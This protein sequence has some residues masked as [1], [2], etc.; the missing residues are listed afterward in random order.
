MGTVVVVAGIVGSLY[1]GFGALLYFMQDALLFPAPGG[2]SVAALDEAAQEVGAKPIRIETS[3]G[4]SLYGWY[5]RGG[6][7]RAVVYFHGNAE[8]VLGTAGLM[9]QVNAEGWDF[10]VIAYRGYPGSEGKPSEEGLLRDARALWDFVRSEEGIPADRIVIH[11]RSLGGGVAVGLAAEVE[12]PAGLV[13]ESTFTSILEMAQSSYSLYP[14]ATLLRHPFDSRQRA[15]AVDAPVLVLHSDQDRVIDVSHGRSLPSLFG[16]ATYV[17][18]PNRGHNDGL[19]VNG[20]EGRAA[21]LD[22][23]DRVAGGEAAL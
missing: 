21:Y 15:R 2:I 6:G 19:I 1:I 14:V 13:L 3:D 9:R 17:E 10:A 4:V 12:K 18:I 11:G 8:T 7:Q 20:S 22:F 5:R 23:L 16:D